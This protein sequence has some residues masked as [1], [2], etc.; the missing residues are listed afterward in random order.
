MNK[1]LKKPP[2]MIHPEYSSIFDSKW[3]ELANIPGKN[4]DKSINW[5]IV[6]IGIIFLIP[7]F[8]FFLWMIFSFARFRRSPAMNV[9]R[10]PSRTGS[11]RSF[12]IGQ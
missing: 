1:L 5:P 9:S 3:D 4:L 12:H 7:F 6:G 8:V 10:I 11:N 2:A